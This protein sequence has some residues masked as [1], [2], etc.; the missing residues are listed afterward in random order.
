M[1]KE[2]SSCL[3]IAY[4]EARR[5]RRDDATRLSCEE[6]TRLAERRGQGNLRGGDVTRLAK[7]QC[8]A[9]TCKEATRDEGT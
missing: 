6:A 8:D 3:Q 9:S 2:A 5:L 4:K 1:L 7:K